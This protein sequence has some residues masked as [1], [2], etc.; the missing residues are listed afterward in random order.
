MHSV[1]YG[2]KIAFAF[3]SLIAIMTLSYT[4]LTQIPSN[5]YAQNEDKNISNYLYDLINKGTLA[6]TL[7]NNLVNYLNELAF[8]LEITSMIPEVGN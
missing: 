8:V 3:L 5:V 7:S 6:K 2:K 1:E 4:V